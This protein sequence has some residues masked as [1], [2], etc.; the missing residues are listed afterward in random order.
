MLVNAC[1]ARG[2]ALLVPMP[3]VVSN[4]E[5]DLLPLQEGH[6]GVAQYLVQIAMPTILLNALLAVMACSLLIRN[7]FN[8][9]ITACSV[10]VASAK[11]VFQDTAQI[12]QKYAC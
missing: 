1:Y 10:I 7:A 4:A 2:T 6:V 11:L 12:L 3:R 5:K 9:Q 8:A